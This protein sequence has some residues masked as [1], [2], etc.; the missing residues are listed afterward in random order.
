[1]G[2]GTRAHK[3]GILHGA[4]Q[5]GQVQ[6]WP[7]VAAQPPAPGSSA[8]AAVAQSEPT[9]T[10]AASAVPDVAVAAGLA[11]AAQD[12]VAVVFGGADESALGAASTAAPVAVQSLRL[13][14][15]LVKRV[16]EMDPGARSGVLAML[17]KDL[18]V[19]VSCMRRS[20]TDK[21]GKYHLSIR[22]NSWHDKVWELHFDKIRLQSAPPAAFDSAALPLLLTMLTVRALP[23]HLRKATPSKGRPLMK[24]R[25]NFYPGFETSREVSPKLALADSAASM[26]LHQDSLPKGDYDDQKV[27]CTHRFAF[28]V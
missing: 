14:A 4:V 21:G 24:P 2:N 26:G 11:A 9:D 3:L 23:G 19:A 20:Y 12:H 1:L 17:Y 15:L 6:S 22:E 16:N 10:A 5:P 7:L 25:V 8:A 13:A 18:T 27:R 28:H